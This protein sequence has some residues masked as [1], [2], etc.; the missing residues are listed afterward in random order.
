MS[1]GLVRA[2]EAS[3][4]GR[5]EEQDR[6]NVLVACAAETIVL[7]LS[8]YRAK[9]LCGRLDVATIQ[10]LGDLAERSGFSVAT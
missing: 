10:E 3:L 8:R 6:P 9:Q 7:A 5:L 2:P 4:L 1:G